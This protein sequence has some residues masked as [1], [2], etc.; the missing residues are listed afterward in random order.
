MIISPTFNTHQYDTSKVIRVKNVSKQKIYIAFGMFP[1]DIY[2]DID[3]ELVMLFE[4]SV[5]AE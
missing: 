5:L 1:C 4:K 2:V 3:G